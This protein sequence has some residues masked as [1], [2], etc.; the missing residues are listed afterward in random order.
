MWEALFK[1]YVKMD[2]H[3]PLTTFGTI[4]S[5]LSSWMHVVTASLP[6]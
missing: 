4:K 1:N 3:D 5:K 2:A 6:V